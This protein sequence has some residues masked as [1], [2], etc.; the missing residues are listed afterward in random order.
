[1]D[2][3]ERHVDGTWWCFDHTEKLWEKLSRSSG[4]QIKNTSTYWDYLE[5]TTGSSPRPKCC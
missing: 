5:T 2:F 4:K 3:G 1:M